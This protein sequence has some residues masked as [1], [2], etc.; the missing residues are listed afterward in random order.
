MDAFRGTATK[1]GN[2]I[3]F[4]QA[5]QIDLVGTADSLLQSRP[6]SG[7][8][9][10]FKNATTPVIQYPNAQILW[11]PIGPKPVL[12]IDE[13]DIPYEQHVVLVGH[14][15]GCSNGRAHTAV[16]ATGSA[17]AANFTVEFAEPRCIANGHGIAQVQ[18]AIAGQRL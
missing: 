8:F 13:R 1:I 11:P 6:I 15:Q 17:V 7:P 16:N 5:F 3:L 4:A 14:G 2:P 10:L 9:D 18:N 12:V